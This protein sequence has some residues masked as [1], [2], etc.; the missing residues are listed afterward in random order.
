MPRLQPI[1]RR[2]FVSTALPVGLWG[3]QRSA[4]S[5]FTWKA[6]LEGA[7][8]APV[9]PLS[10]WYR[11]PA[12]SWDEALPVGNGRLGAMVFGG[13]ETERLQLNEETLWAGFEHDASNPASLRHLAE[14]RRLLFAGHELEATELA[15]KTMLGLPSA[16]E[17]YQPLADLWIDRRRSTTERSTRPW[18]RS[19]PGRGRRAA[20]RP[21]SPRPRRGCAPSR[22]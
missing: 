19:A 15:S 4:S 2:L 1:S 20:R 13:V 14:V 3:F 21:P 12:R 18:R 10:L 16:I 6:R 17:S 5:T 9:A 7:A 22:G 8:A 11:Q